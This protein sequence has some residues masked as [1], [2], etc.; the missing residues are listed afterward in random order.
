MQFKIEDF[1]TLLS[2]EITRSSS[3]GTVLIKVDGKE[4]TLRILKFGTNEF[5]FILG[6]SFHHAK[7]LSSSS[8][9]TK[10]IIDGEPLTIKKHSKYRAGLF[11]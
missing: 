9:E 8:S 5:E 11:L 7:I 1:Q 6:H 2:G 10:M 4:Q 3:D